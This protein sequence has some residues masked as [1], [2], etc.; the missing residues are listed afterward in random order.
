[1]KAPQ[2]DSTTSE[3]G[4]PRRFGH[5]KRVINVIDVRQSYLQQ[6]LYESLRRLGFTE[7]ANNSIH[8][9]YE[10]VTLSAPTA[11][12]LGVDTSDGRD[13]YPMSGRKGIEI[14]A[15]DLINAAM[16]RMLETKPDLPP[17]TAAR[18]AASA[19][20]YFMIRYNLQQV[21][22]LDMDEALRP[23]GDTGVYLQ[24]AYARA[25]SILR[26]LAG[27]G[28]RT[29]E[30]L[31]T[32]PEQLEQSEWDLLRHIDAY[33]RSL[34]EASDKLA[35]YMLASYV[36]DLAA[37][38]SDFYEHTSPILRET[39]EQVKAFRSSLV[40]ATVQ[41]MDNALRVLGFVPLES[42]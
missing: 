22:A 13:F 1:M 17:E 35:P 39:N 40:R 23:N 34:A 20:R 27:E 36:Y 38:F 42:I 8:L 12:R 7:Q 18:L 10:V 6:V 3:E 21:I 30:R 41:T 2:D 19:I 14:K 31:E 9:A 28:Y 15:D 16:E 25:N 29:P 4:D 26:K 11:A 5:A 24:Y 33:P 37:H 32:L